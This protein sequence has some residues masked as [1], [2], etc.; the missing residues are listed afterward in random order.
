MR[1]RTPRC[2]ARSRARG[3]ARSRRC[4]RRAGGRRAG[5]LPVERGAREDPEQD[6]V[7][8]QVP[9]VAEAAVRVDSEQLRGVAPGRRNP[10]ALASPSVAGQFV[11]HVGTAARWRFR[12]G[13]WPSRRVE[14]DAPDRDRAHRD[15]ADRRARRDRPTEPTGIEPTGTPVIARPRTVLA[16]PTLRQL[17]PAITAAHQSVAPPGGAARASRR[18]GSR[19]NSA[20][21][22]L[23]QAALRERRASNRAFAVGLS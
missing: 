7:Q 1:S 16:L 2:T 8:D 19:R 15:G 14:V 17:P 10:C 12:P 4:L 22:R 23:A 13:C 9:E 18:A 11:V 21:D 5:L 6:V 3:S 20:Q